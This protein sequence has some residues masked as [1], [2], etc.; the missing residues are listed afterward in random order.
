MTGY[1]RVHFLAAH[2][3]YWEN[4]Y[5]FDLKTK[6]RLD[7]AADLCRTNGALPCKHPAVLSFTNM[8]ENSEQCPSIFMNNGDDIVTVY[9]EY[10][11][12]SEVE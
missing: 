7:K 8:L 4:F 2:H 12:V 10:R 1:Y 3:G 11:T 6:E 5:N 9:V